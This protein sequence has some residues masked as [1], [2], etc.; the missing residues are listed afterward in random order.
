MML[1]LLLLVLIGPG[2]AALF[3]GTADSRDPEYG[4]GPVL[5]HGNRP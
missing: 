3:G 1:M 5:G 4:L 2:I